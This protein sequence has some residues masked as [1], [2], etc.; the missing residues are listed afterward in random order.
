[1]VYNMLGQEMM[2]FSN[3]RNQ[4]DISS[5]K[6]GFFIMK[7]ILE[8]SESKII[9]FVKKVNKIINDT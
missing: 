6:S 8:N 9:R 4:Y 3:N 1:M 5:L 2:K 7:V